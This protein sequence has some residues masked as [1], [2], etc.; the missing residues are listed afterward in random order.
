MINR[1]MAVK[2]WLPDFPLEERF[3]H[4]ADR[5]LIHIFS[6][7]P[8]PLPICFECAVTSLRDLIGSTDQ[9]ACQQWKSK[10]RGERGCWMRTSLFSLFKEQQRFARP[11]RRKH[12]FGLWD[13]LTVNF[14]LT[15]STQQFFVFFFLKFCSDPNR[16]VWRYCEE[17]QCWVSWSQMG[18]IT[19]VTV[20]LQL[21]SHNV[22]VKA[23]RIL[24]ISSA[25][26]FYFPRCP[27]LT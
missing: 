27:S 11:K 24:I 22:K 5:S 7:S 4:N 1:L 3:T 18:H 20:S 6:N 12:L 2:L 14:C 25:A 8:V 16:P 23:R 17:G 21:L 19:P 10:A 15:L 26:P 13:V 9:T